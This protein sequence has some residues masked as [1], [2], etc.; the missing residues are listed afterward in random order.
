MD[1][2][3]NKIAA[4]ANIAAYNPELTKDYIDGAPHVKHESLR[5][6][7]GELIVRVFDEA[8]KHNATPRVL[9]RWQGQGG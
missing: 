9:D 6:L 5:R 4:L 2:R 8:K 3:V 1:K 7:Y